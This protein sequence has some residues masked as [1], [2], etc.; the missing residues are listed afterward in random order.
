MNE[1][2]YN[3][4]Q[5]V[6]IKL[7]KKEKTNKTNK[8]NKDKQMNNNNKQ[9]TASLQRQEHKTGRSTGLQ[10]AFARAPPTPQD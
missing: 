7:F 10:T 6:H 1:H 5:N 4:V 8:Q 9:K 3:G 2:S